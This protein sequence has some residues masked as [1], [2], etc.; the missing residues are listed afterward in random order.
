VAP[1]IRTTPLVG[2]ATSWPAIRE[3]SVPKGPVIE[4]IG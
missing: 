3:T 1:R 2:R 4:P